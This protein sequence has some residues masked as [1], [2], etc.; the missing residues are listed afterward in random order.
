MKNSKQANIQ[1][2]NKYKIV[3]E[4]DKAMFEYETETIKKR[5]I[6]IR[7]PRWF[8]KLVRGIKRP[9]R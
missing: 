7:S 2:G 8:D 3:N 1:V 9:S 4:Q 6:S 5:K